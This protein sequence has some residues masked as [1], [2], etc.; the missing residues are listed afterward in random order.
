MAPS[1]MPNVG[2]PTSNAAPVAT[3]SE[4][5]AIVKPPL[6]LSGDV[7]SGPVLTC[8]RCVIAGVGLLTISAALWPLSQYSYILFHSLVELISIVIGCGIFVTTWNTRHIHR[9]GFFV[10]LGCAYFAI[11]VLGMLHM[12]AYRGI[13]AFPYEGADLPTQLWVCMRGV[14]AVSLVLL[15][16]MLGRPSP[17]PKLILLSYAVLTTLLVLLTVV[18]HRFPTAFDEF[19]PNPGL[20]PFKRTMEYVFAGLIALAAILLVGRRNHFEPTVYRLLLLALI[21]AVFQ[22]LSF[23]LYGSPTGTWNWTGHVLQFISFALVY[24]AVLVPAL[25]RPYDLLLRDVRLNAQELQDNTQQ[26]QEAKH[27][28][29]EAS[30]AKD[31]FLAV[32]SH[33]LRNPLNPVMVTLGSVEKRP[34]LPPDLIED[35]QLIRRNVE[36]EARLIDDLL[37][38][39]RISRGKLELQPRPSDVHQLLTQ[40]I[41]ICRASLEDKAMTVRCEWNATSFGAS[42]DPVRMM[43]VL[44]NVLKNAVK[45]SPPGG[46]IVART[47]NENDR[48]VIDVVDGGIG[49]EPAWRSQI[50]EAFSQAG[51]THG[52]LGL[53]L[54]I[55][56]ALLDAQHGTIEARSEGLGRGATF[57]M[58]LPTCPLPVAAVSQ[59]PQPEDAEQTSLRVLLVEDHPDTA[60]IME[61]LIRARGFDVTSAGSVAE[62]IDAG[63]EQTFDLL[64][65]DLG[66]PDGSGHDVMRH[67]RFTHGDIRG[68]ALSGYGMEHDIRASHDAGFDAHFVKPIDF[69]RLI[70]AIGEI[71]SRE[72]ST[73]N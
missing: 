9:N 37:D 68:I 8:R 5:V 53:G 56:K 39:T 54:A 42:V 57:R 33:E 16:L 12:L 55:S 69:E 58:T 45:F 51:R 25:E 49:I 38:L 47:F 46:E 40:A 44:W 18:W 59:T 36:L 62:A 23:T 72:S 32:L 65:S 14:H 1:A 24:R 15:M 63:S 3:A 64:L 21:V 71:M 48:L 52:G 27:L 35:L 19:G 34:D 41:E 66:L 70:T 61:R 50:F 60:R 73:T 4:G 17:R 6:H 7:S 30:R 22:G 28:A 2:L 11:S 20:T 29:E 26:L 67:L 13:N 31:E 10:T 43:Q